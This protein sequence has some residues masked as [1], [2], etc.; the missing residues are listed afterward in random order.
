[1]MGAE[2]MSMTRHIDCWPIGNYGPFDRFVADCWAL[3]SKIDTGRDRHIQKILRQ[4]I[5]KASQGDY[6]PLPILSLGSNSCNINI[7]PVVRV[8][9]HSGIYDV[10]T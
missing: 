4:P 9:D 6:N 3:L 2:H 5:A 1:M 7:A 10:T 8:S